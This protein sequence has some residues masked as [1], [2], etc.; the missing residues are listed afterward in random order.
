[1]EADSS[2]LLRIRCPSTLS[3]WN[4]LLLSR[5]PAAA[6]TFP[7]SSTSAP[8]SIRHSNRCCCEV[9]CVMASR[10][11][12]AM[13]SPL[14]GNP[15][16]RPPLPTFVGASLS[17][18]GCELRAPRNEGRGSRVANP[19]PTPQDG[20]RPKGQGPTPEPRPQDGPTLMPNGKRAYGWAWGLGF[21]A[22]TDRSVP[23]P[24][25]PR[26]RPDRPEDRG[27]RTS[28]ICDM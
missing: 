9:R 6:A 28:L 24:P 1:M 10:H 15:C 16:W 18:N 7:A 17:Q 12:C 21:G 2:P 3:S 25:P 8:S 22:G 5:S 27:Q 20:P 14:V 13:A 4:D 26:G 19:R 11:R 23:H